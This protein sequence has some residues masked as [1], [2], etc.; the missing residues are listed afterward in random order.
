[1]QLHVD[2]EI[3]QINLNV[4]A[5]VIPTIEGVRSEMITNIEYH[6]HF[7]TMIQESDNY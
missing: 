3:P 6:F 1:L 4:K 2:L 5:D 7:E